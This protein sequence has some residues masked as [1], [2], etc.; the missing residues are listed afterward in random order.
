MSSRRA[1]PAPRTSS[2][3][4]ATRWRRRAAAG[5]NDPM[6]LM[7]QRL[8]LRSAALGLGAAGL[9]AAGPLRAAPKIG[10]LLKGD[11]SFWHAVEAGCRAA[12]QKAGAEVVV[13]MPPTESDVAIQVRMLNEMAGQGIQG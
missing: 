10:V 11:T 12:A 5:W 6:T 2:T 3:R 13:L 9:L 7:L 4:S 1:R 8:L